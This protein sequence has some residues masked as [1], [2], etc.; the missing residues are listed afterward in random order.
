[1][2][3]KIRVE[4]RGETKGPRITQGCQGN[5]RGITTEFEVDEHNTTIYLEA[6]GDLTTP[7]Q[8]IQIS[9]DGAKLDKFFVKHEY[10]VSFYLDE[11]N[12]RKVEKPCFPPA[13][14]CATKRCVC[15]T[16]IH[17]NTTDSDLMRVLR[18]VYLEAM[19]HEANRQERKGQRQKR[20]EEGLKRVVEEAFQDLTG[21]NRGYD[22]VMDEGCRNSEFCRHCSVHRKNSTHDSS[23]PHFNGGTC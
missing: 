3:T 2:T 8:R 13:C 20:S 4:Q 22:A 21:R 17:S 1:M 6:H 19:Y 18:D 14:V 5:S 7:R 9:P 16:V 15:N 10:G 11:V 23:C 12:P